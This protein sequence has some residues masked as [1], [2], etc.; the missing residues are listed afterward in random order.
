MGRFALRPMLDYILNVKPWGWAIGYGVAF[1][2]YGGAYLIL[3]HFEPHSF[4][5]PAASLEPRYQT[6]QVTVS[7]ML[8]EDLRDRFRAGGERQ[9]KKGRYRIYANS[10]TLDQFEIDSKGIVHIAADL[11]VCDF[12]MGCG[13]PGT[14]AWSYRIGFRATGRPDQMFKVAF[15]VDDV[16]AKKDRIWFIYPA[17]K[18]NIDEFLIPT[19][20]AKVIENRPLLFSF[21]SD[22]PIFQTPRASQEL[23]GLIEE[24]RGW[25]SPNTAEY[26]VR[27][28]YLSAVTITTTGY[29]DIVPLTSTARILTASEALAGTVLLGLF[30]YS[31]PARRRPPMATRNGADPPAA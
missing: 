24:T 10:V 21:D 13:P 25:P 29:G 9:E 31:L 5:Q 30:I 14:P 22:A 2:A 8:L 19:I 1:V 6:E 3:S 11:P 16:W 27:M 18:P 4:H 26:A 15:Q 23:A 7:K 17:T 20:I 12:V 28:L